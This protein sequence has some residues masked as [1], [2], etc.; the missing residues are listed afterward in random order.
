MIETSAIAN[1]GLKGTFLGVFLLLT[2]SI[3]MFLSCWF[4]WKSFN[5]QQKNIVMKESKV[6]YV[7]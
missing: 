3:I 7:V 4:A 2:N 6:T 1:L 5:K